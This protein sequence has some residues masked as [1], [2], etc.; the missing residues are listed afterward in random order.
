MG[1]RGEPT[2]GGRAWA[3]AARTLLGVRGGAAVPAPPSRSMASDVSGTGLSAVV[4]AQLARIREVQR[5][6]ASY[7]QRTVF[8]EHPELGF[9]QLNEDAP[10]RY[11]KRTHLGI[12]ERLAL[13]QARM[14]GLDRVLDNVPAGDRL[15]TVLDAWVSLWT[16]RLIADLRG[17]GAGGG[18]SRGG[19]G[20]G[21]EGGLFGNGGQVL[22]G[23]GL[24]RI[25]VTG[26]GV[27]RDHRRVGRS[28][29]HVGALDFR[30]D[31]GVV[32]TAAV[33]LRP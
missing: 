23:G 5:D 13:L 7:H 18:G 10:L 20:G 4:R 26:L 30:V 12:E 28:C 25:P 8:E 22:I 16:A 15:P 29:R 2:G 6:V 1:L 27:V 19:V 32:V 17:S 11:G 33:G 24:D 3:R 9:F 21:G 31:A 14:P